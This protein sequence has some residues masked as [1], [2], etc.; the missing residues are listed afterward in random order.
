MPNRRGQTETRKQPATQQQAS[1]VLP[2][3]SEERAI[4]SLTSEALLSGDSAKIAELVA[5]HGVPAK[6]VMDLAERFQTAADALG[7]AAMLAGYPPEGEDEE[8]EEDEEDDDEQG[9][10]KANS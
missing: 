10:T 8:D 5:R 4:A 9:S 6:R 3:S 2:L 7:D 1:H